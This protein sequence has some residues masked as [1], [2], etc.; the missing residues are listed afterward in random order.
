MLN[1]SLWIAQLHILFQDQTKMD[2]PDFIKRYDRNYYKYWVNRAG[3]WENKEQLLTPF[4][5]KFMSDGVP[6]LL[7]ST[8]LIHGEYYPSNIFNQNDAIIPLDWETAA[9]GPGEI[10]IAALIESWPE[11]MEQDCYSVY[12][13]HRWSGNPPIN[14][15][16]RLDFAKAYLHI[17][18]LGKADHKPFN[19]KISWRLNEIVQLGSRL[20]WI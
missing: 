8:T 17:R 10:D 19:K 1:A 7:D 20:G 14:L 15:K 13:E 9:V 12:A 3:I 2:L 18:N 6:S 5:E 16:E 11:D 4:L